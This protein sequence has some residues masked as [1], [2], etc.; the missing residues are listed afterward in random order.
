MGL[1]ISKRVCRSFQTS[2]EFNSA[3][4]SVYE[5][6]L[7]LSQD[8]FS[9]VRP[10]QLLAASDR[11]HYSLS[12][13]PHVHPLIAKWVP[14][15]PTRSQVD[16]AL[17]EVVVVGKDTTLELGQAD[18]K[19]F[20]VEVFTDAVVS[21]AG[22]AVLRRIPIGVAGIAG[23]GMVSRSGKDLVGTAI[24]VYALGVATSIYL[25]LAI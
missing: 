7:K 21:N 5:E 3:C 12:A 4:D 8:A 2:P 14:T 19:A 24:G 20:A 18:F 13:M 17:R 10:Y 16:K 1:S 11:L 25:S 23:V 22:K 6:C 9:G 15:P